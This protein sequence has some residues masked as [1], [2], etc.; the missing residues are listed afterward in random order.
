MKKAIRIATSLILII[1]LIL[2]IMPISAMANTG[3]G[4]LC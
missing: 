2:P 3:D 4:T 1:L